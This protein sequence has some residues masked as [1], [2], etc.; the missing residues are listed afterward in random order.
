MKDA[1]YEYV[2]VDDCWMAMNRTADGKLTHDP[3][4]F[5]SGM[6]ATANYVQARG[7]KFVRTCSAVA[8]NLPSLVPDVWYVHSHL[9]RADGDCRGCIRRVVG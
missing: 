6:K 8:R 2:N 4:R 9:R 5:P 3:V 7:L 1:G